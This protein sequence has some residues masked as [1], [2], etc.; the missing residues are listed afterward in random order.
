MDDRYLSLLEDLH[1]RT[2]RQG[3]GGDAETLKA[4]ALAELDEATPLRI[5]DIGCGT[6]GPTLQLAQ[7][8]NADIVAIDFMPGFIA[9]LEQRAAEQG[10]SDKITPLVCSMAQLPFAAEEFDVIW[11]EGA[12]YNIGF[13]AGVK[14]W[15]RFLKPGGIL[16][17]SEI[18]WITGTRPPEVQ[19]HWCEEYPEIAPASSK[20][21]VLEKSGYAPMGYFVLPENCWLENYYHPLRDQLPEF[22]ARHQGDATTAMIAEAE[23]A[24]AAL[25]ETY[26]AYYS[27]GV[28]VARKCD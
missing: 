22:I 26:K 27:Y 21:E 15:R 7:S 5:A 6:G 17:V 4:I 23:E 16:V 9:V 20:I 18:T 12:I 3:P 19:R 24:E 28:Y 2:S 25:Y 10:L 14:A 1:K 11:S 8:L 13:E